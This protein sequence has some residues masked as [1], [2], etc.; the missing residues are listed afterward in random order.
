MRAGRREGRRRGGGGAGFSGRGCALSAA[1]APRPPLPLFFLSFLSLSLSCA[2]RFSFLDEYCVPLS[3]AASPFP[4]SPPPCVCFGEKK[5]ECVVRC[6]VRWVSGRGRR[7]GGEAVSSTLAPSLCPRPAS[8]LC[9]PPLPPWA[10]CAW[11]CVCVCVCVCV[12]RG[13]ERGP[14]PQP[15]NPPLLARR[16][17]RSFPA[18]ASR[19]TK[20]KSKPVFFYHSLPPPPIR[21]FFLRGRQSGLPPW[22]DL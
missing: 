16:R 14:P 12:W 15:T 1:L 6:V 8:P 2:R 22:R 5:N 21:H 9:L 7:G 20:S 18:R 17:R 10:G 3:S 19:N 11:V 13:A 4:L